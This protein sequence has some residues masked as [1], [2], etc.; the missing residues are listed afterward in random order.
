MKSPYA[1]AVVFQWKTYEC[2]I[3]YNRNLDSNTDGQGQARTDDTE[4]ED[5]I[6]FGVFAGVFYTSAP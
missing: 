4:T 6:G 5:V 3:E 1:C 2:F